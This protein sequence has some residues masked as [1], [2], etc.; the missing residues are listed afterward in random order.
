MI[1]AAGW[2]FNI[3]F[4][5]WIL[6]IL[7]PFILLLANSFGVLV[8]AYLPPYDLN[9]QMSLKSTSTFFISLVIILAPFALIVSASSV[10][11]QAAYLI[12]LAAYSIL[13]TNIFLEGAS[14]GFEKLELKRVLPRNPRLEQSTA[15][16]Q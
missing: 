4:S 3:S 1:L 14:K 7:L 5:E 8:G 6:G 9:N 15:A 10:P 12:M 2:I 11:L 16:N 13:V